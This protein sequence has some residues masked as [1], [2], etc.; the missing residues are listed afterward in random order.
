MSSRK[1]Y[2]EEAKELKLATRVYDDDVLVQES[3]KYIQ[4]L[5]DRCAPSSLKA[6]KSQ[7]YQDLIKEPAEALD[8]ADKAMLTSFGGPDMKE[9]VSAYMEKRQPKFARI[10]KD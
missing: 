3:I 5:A 2:G 4:D 9:G 10:G 6:I 8:Y 1:I 7:I